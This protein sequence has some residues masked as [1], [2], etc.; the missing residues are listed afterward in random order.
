MR[1]VFWTFIIFLLNSCAWFCRHHNVLIEFAMSKK[2]AIN[3]Q[4]LTPVYKKGGNT[5]LVLSLPSK[6]DMHIL[7]NYFNHWCEQL[8][9]LCYQFFFIDNAFTGRRSSYQFLASAFKTH[10]EC[11]WHISMENFAKRVG[12]TNDDAN[13]RSGAVRLAHAMRYIL[14]QLVCTKSLVCQ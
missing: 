2:R 9:Q 11:K 13:K 7:Q 1:L 10:G 14:I 4:F 3:G 12:I 8:R 6:F 5:K